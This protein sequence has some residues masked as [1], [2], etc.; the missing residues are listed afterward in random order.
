MFK[1][2]L[3]DQCQNERSHNDII[4]TICL[5]VHL[6]DIPAHKCAY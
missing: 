4:R 1:N 5:E 6:K 2:M 3:K